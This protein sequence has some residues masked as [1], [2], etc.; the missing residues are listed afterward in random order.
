MWQTCRITSYLQRDLFNALFF[1]ETKERVLSTTNCYKKLTLVRHRILS[2]QSCTTIMSCDLFCLYS[3]GFFLFA[4][5]INKH[6][7][8]SPAE[9]EYLLF[10]DSVSFL[11]TRNKLRWSECVTHDSASYQITL[12]KKKKKRVIQ[13]VIFP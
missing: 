1:F 10:C 3:L 5:L 11:S 7:Y 2:I 12:L 8:H 13:I 6:P 9:F 4:I